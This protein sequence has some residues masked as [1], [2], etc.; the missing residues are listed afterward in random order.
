V[1]TTRDSD[2]RNSLPS[3][4]LSF[5]QDDFCA[6]HKAS[7]LT[8]QEVSGT[9][10]SGTLQLGPDH[11]TPWG[12][13]HGGIYSTAAE[14]TASLGAS[15]AVAEKRLFAVGVNN[16]TDFLRPVSKGVLRVE[17]TPV[18]QGRTQQLWLVTI[19]REDGR[20]VSRSQ[21]RLQNVPLTD[22]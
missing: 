22:Q 8:L 15:A 16:S 11:Q 18:F 14:A 6:F 1:D 9:R 21:V 19:R 20:D 3:A 13:V 4:G 7:G 2:G 12:V 17:A 5:N 10:V